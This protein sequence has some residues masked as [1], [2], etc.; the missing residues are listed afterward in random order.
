VPE[1]AHHPGPGYGAP[2]PGKAT[3]VNFSL[4]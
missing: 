3:S 1:P 2:E 4:C